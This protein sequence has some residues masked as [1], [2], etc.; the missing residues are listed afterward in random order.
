M[1]VGGLVGTR[2]GR[3]KAKIL[4]L[5]LLTV[6]VSSACVSYTPPLRR[7]TGFSTSPMRA[8]RDEA[9]QALVS[10]VTS[11]NLAIQTSDSGAG[12]L[13]IGPLNFLS[14]ADC[15]TFTSQLDP[16]QFSVPMGSILFHVDATGSGT[17]LR[18]NADVAQV[19]YQLNTVLW[20]WQP[21]HVLKCESLDSWETEI[22]TRVREVLGPRGEFLER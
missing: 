5:L 18:A 16:I 13:R 14:R 1:H 22:F 10:A 12:V 3:A 19:V 15:G 7:S 8:S 2:G 4:T 6:T 21:T 9:F 17:K 20:A 11:L